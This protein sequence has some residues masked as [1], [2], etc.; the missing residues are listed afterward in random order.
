MCSR[1]RHCPSGPMLR[2]PGSHS[3]RSRAVS[4]C[5][6][7]HP[8]SRL[9]PNPLGLT[10]GWTTSGGRTRPSA[11]LRWTAYISPRASAERASSLQVDVR[12]CGDRSRVEL[13]SPSTTRTWP[14]MKLPPGEQRKVIALGIYRIA[15]R[16][17]RRAC[18]TRLPTGRLRSEP[19]E[20]IHGVVAGRNLAN[21][22]NPGDPARRCRRGTIFLGQ[23]VGTSES[24]RRRECQG[25]GGL[26]SSWRA[27]L[28]RRC[29]RTA[30]AG[31]RPGQGR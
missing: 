10:T 15:L 1:P 21:D 26:R 25:L 22:L 14:S 2:R 5:C 6:R 30:R 24:D 31:R 28:C 4:S 16:S 18:Q 3:R 7:T 19:L 11:P 23:P 12:A 27:C 13:D 20:R 17:Q 29:G 9:G 8:C